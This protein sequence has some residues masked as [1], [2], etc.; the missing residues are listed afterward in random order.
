MSTVRRIAKNTTVVIGWNIANRL[1]SL[2]IAIYL[3]R[4]LGVTGYGNYSFISAYV[5]FFG[6][7]VDL[8]INTFLV[9]EIAKYRKRTEE[10]VANGIGIKLVLFLIA[11]L[12][13]S[14]IISYLNYPSEVKISVY[15]A[16]FTLLFSS[17]TSLLS[18]LFQADLEMLYPA[19]ADLA[20]R[21][22]LGAL[23]LF[24]S[25]QKGGLVSIILASLAANVFSFILLYLLSK[26][27]TSVSVK[28]DIE[29]WKEIL[30]PAVLLGLSGIFSSV[31]IRMD[32]ILLSLLKGNTEVGFYSVPSQLTDS[33]TLIPLAFMSSMFPLMSSYSK[34]SKDSLS[35]SFRLAVKYMLM[36]AIPMAFGITLLSDR[37]ITAIY[38]AEF[39]PS[40]PALVIMIWCHILV[41]CVIVFDTLLVSI[42][43]Q[44]KVFV[45]TGVTAIFNV[46]ANLLLIP[47]LGFIGAA[48]ALL[49]S[50]LLATV[51]YLHY[52]PKSFKLLDWRFVIRSALASFLM[53]LF[54]SYSNLHMYAIIPIAAIL[55]F[56]FLAVL[57]GISKED[58]EIFKKLRV[59]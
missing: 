19:F 35:K 52:L 38:G 55:Y 39:L 36:L 44:R 8:G 2:L 53:S 50:Y 21:L 1:V 54:I 33:T 10:L 20:G 5:L 51:L 7:I 9:R 58:I 25:Y 45:A 6:V 32:T 41:F 12:L 48:I 23:I 29:I 31:I 56:I 27:K 26:R 4:Y 59:K 30:E 49:L 37:I 24:I 16:T 46:V 15:I 22:L 40:S 17:T 14:I 57:G 18:T 34:V 28:F 43:L 42:E 11:F 13:S 3:A 47:Q